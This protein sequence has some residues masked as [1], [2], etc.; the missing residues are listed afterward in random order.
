[1]DAL[2]ADSFRSIG[3]GSSPLS[4]RLSSVAAWTNASNAPS[5]PGLPCDPKVTAGDLGG[6]ALSKLG[7]AVAEDV[8]ET[9]EG[10]EP[11]CV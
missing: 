7:S 11:D 8:R 1:M 2:R 3:V 4:R 10:G 6:S 5:P 9:T